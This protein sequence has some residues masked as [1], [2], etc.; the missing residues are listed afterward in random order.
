M[1]FSVTF[2]YLGLHSQLQ[3]EKGVR[4][5][6]LDERYWPWI[7]F[8]S[9]WPEFWHCTFHI[10]QTDMSQAQAAYLRHKFK[11][12]ESSGA[13]VA[14][15][16]HVRYP[17]MNTSWSRVENDQTS[18]CSGQALKCARILHCSQRLFLNKDGWT[19]WQHQPAL[20]I[21]QRSKN[22]LIDNR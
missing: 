14:H 2:L 4:H 18:S 17:G 20:T 21:P 11:L 19:C 1:C 16:K 10:F 6:K 9:T 5:S 8:Q 7:V 3:D 13:W 22:L 12:T 15:W